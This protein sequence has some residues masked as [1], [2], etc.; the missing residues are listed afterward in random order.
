LQLQ[1]IG[2]VFDSSGLGQI[3][4]DFCLA[5]YRC[6]HIFNI[7]DITLLPSDNV[8]GRYFFEADQ[9]EID[10]SF[11]RSVKIEGPYACL[12]ILP[13]DR[14]TLDHGASKN[15]IW[16]LYETDSIPSNWL[17]ILND[18]HVSEVWV[19]TEFHRNSFNKSGVCSYIRI[20]PFGYDEKKYNLCS[21]PLANFADRV[22]FYFIFISEFKKPKGCDLLLNVFFSV[23]KNRT[24]VKL[25]FKASSSYREDIENYVLAVKEAHGA[26]NE[27]FLVSGQLPEHT[28]V[29]LYA[30]GD[31]FVH[32]NRG[33]GWGLTL[34][35]SM[36]CGVPVITSNYSAQ[37]LYCSKQNSLLISGLECEILD[38]AWLA[39]IPQQRGHKWFEPDQ[40]VLSDLLVYAV[41]NRDLLHEMGLRAAEDVK[42]FTWLESVKQA[43][44]F[45][46]NK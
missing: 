18:P 36:A 1:I 42:K 11:C 43:A 29:S 6:G 16:T 23:F 14:I 41:N 3:A 32:P 22:P 4:R 2:P 26:T 12:H 19:P 37:K 21:K 8:G 33:E 28:M 39:A 31:C 15:Y 45:I 34:L 44:E 7:I 38:E 27:V 40:K 9:D 24:D 13:P 35:Q 30:S 10:I 5:L 46:F 17:S 25:I 20:I